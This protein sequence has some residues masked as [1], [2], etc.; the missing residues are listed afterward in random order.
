MKKKFG[1]IILRHVESKKHDKLW[2]ECYDCIRKH[3]KHNLIVIIDDNSDYS[4]VSK[5]ELKN[6]I[7][8]ESKYKKRGELLPYLYFL[9]N[10][11]F[12]TA[13]I[14]HDS[15]FLQ[16]RIRRN[17]SHIDDVL[18]LWHF[19]NNHAENFIGQENIIKTLDNKEEILDFHYKKK[20]WVG[21]FGVMTIIRKD[22]LNQV[23]KKYNLFG[24]VD[25]V[26]CR[27]DRMCLERVLGCLFS[28]EK[29]TEEKSLLGNVVQNENI[30]W[31]LDFDQYS[32]FLKNRKN[33]LSV[34]KVFSSR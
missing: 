19:P 2:R 28:K 11:W 12:D 29:K 34:I 20:N 13:V 6:T 15:V 26:Q 25:V 17:L 1:F 7:L 8:V 18:F 14:L 5:K 33:P 3:Y 30:I 16:N 24:M 10:H 27:D 31:G 23:D 4:I 32:L 22:F 9:K 21:C